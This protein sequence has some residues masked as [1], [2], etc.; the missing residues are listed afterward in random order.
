V[1]TLLTQSLTIGRS[2]ALRALRQ[3]AQQLI[4]AHN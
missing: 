4:Q 3:Q 1:Q 2:P